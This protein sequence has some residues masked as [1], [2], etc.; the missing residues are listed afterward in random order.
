M[1]LF[2]GYFLK[3]LLTNFYDFDHQSITLSVIQM[4]FWL[5]PNRDINLTHYLR[6][7]KAIIGCHLALSYL[8]FCSL[9]QILL[10][11]FVKYSAF[12]NC[13]T[14]HDHFYPR[15]IYNMNRVNI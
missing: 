13:S 3:C 12:T 8:D 9:I 4:L 7:F 5:I 10:A 1:Y 11:F 6:T 14:F 2:L 15:K